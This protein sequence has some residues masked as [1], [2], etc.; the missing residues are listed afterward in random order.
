MKDEMKRYRFNVPTN[1]KSVLKWISNQ[2]NVS[3]SIRQLIRDD[4]RRNGFSDYTCRDVMPF[5]YSD[6]VKSDENIS[7]IK[8]ETENNIKEDILNNNE[9]EEDNLNQ[10]IEVIS[11][12]I[13][14]KIKQDENQ[15]LIENENENDDSSMDDILASML[16]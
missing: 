4:I 16:S 12:E 1:D 10:N 13:K 11:E 14:E 8:F 7:T 2:S 15:E 3:S 6:D 5:V 9:I